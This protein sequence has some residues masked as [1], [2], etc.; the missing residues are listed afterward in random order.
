MHVGALLSSAEHGRS[1]K[2]EEPS[3]PQLSWYNNKAG[4]ASHTAHLTALSAHARLQARTQVGVGAHVHGLLLAPHHLQIRSHL[5]GVCL[6]RSAPPGSA[7]G[8]SPKRQPCMTHSASSHKKGTLMP[9]L[10]DH[11][12]QGLVKALG[13]ACTQANG[14][15]QYAGRPHLSIRVASELTAHQIKGKGCQLQHRHGAN[16]SAGSQSTPGNDISGRP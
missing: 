14:S 13:D 2:V 6:S 12:V 10:Q 8:I 11:A 7:L 5:S 9:K 3:V 4:S 1:K 15:S 16:M